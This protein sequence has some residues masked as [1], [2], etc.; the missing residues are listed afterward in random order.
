MGGPRWK[1]PETLRLEQGPEL[2]REVQEATKGSASLRARVLKNLQTMVEECWRELD[3]AGKDSSNLQKLDASLLLMER[4]LVVLQLGASVSGQTP[5]L[6][7]LRL[8]P[9]RLNAHGSAC[10]P[11]ELWQRL[12]SFSSALDAAAKCNAAMEQLQQQAAAEDEQRQPARIPCRS[13]VPTPTATPPPGSPPRG[14]RGRAIH[15]RAIGQEARCAES[16]QFLQKAR[17]AQTPRR[18]A[19]NPRLP[20]I[21]KAAMQHA[22]PRKQAAL[23][24]AGPPS[25]DTALNISIPTLDELRQEVQRERDAYLSQRLACSAR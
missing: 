8:A 3:A 2:T 24:L 7:T 6:S 20:P 25:I 22:A 1:P 13:T 4:Q 15:S 18:P 17:E 21:T 14:L 19:A 10:S 9:L 11:E 5:R 16:E 12:H 23:Q